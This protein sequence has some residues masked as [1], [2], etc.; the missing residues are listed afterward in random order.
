MEGL[1]RNFPNRAMGILLRAIVMPLGKR[2]HKPSDKI[3]HEVAR[4]L[5]APNEARERLLQGLYQD[6]DD[7]KPYGMIEEA[8]KKIIAA[9]QPDAGK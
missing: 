9:E 4:I 8:L 7:N 1:L 3:G 2:V 5:L 6:V